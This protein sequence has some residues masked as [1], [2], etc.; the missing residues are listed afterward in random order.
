[1]GGN[2]KAGGAAFWKWADQIGIVDALAQGF[3]I[4]GVFGL[5]GGAM[6][7]AWS[8]LAGMPGPV[9]GTLALIAF[10][11]VLWAWNALTWRS[12]K[13]NVGKPA[14]LTTGVAGE[15]EEEAI[16]LGSWTV[17]KR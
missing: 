4:K 11:G 9:N 12:H 6:M 13:G 5:I 15:K 14:S 8:Y 16:L 7:A 3:G 17:R 10:V 2:W 1:M